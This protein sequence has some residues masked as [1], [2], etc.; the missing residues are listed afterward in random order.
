MVVL[1][2]V[3]MAVMVVGDENIKFVME[4]SNLFVCILWGEGRSTE[5]MIVS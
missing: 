1:M 3:V 2:I 4:I 5:K